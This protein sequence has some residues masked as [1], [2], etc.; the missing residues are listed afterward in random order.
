[1]YKE[2]LELRGQLRQLRG[3][4]EKQTNESEEKLAKAEK[5]VLGW[6]AWDQKLRARIASL[7]DTVNYKEVLELRGQLRQLRDEKEEKLK[8]E[9][10]ELEGSYE[11][12]R[13][14]LVALIAEAEE[15]YRKLKEESEKLQARVTKAESERRSLQEQVK[16]DAVELSLLKEE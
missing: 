3:D 13:S 16:G 8:D 5:A 7:K 4:L 11:T 2:V 1:N 6:S 12:E 9:L 10:L 14:T 15:D